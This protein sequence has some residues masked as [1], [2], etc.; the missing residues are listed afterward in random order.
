MLRR[1]RLGVLGF[2]LV[3][4]LFAVAVFDA[5]YVHVQSSQTYI[6]YAVALPALALVVARARRTAVPRSMSV[7]IVVWVEVAVAHAAIAW[8]AQHPTNLVGSDLAAVLMPVVVLFAALANPAIVG[9]QATKIVLAGLAVAAVVAA[10]VPQVAGRHEKPSTLIAAAS[11]LW[12]ADRPSW[13]RAAA[14]GAVAYLGWSSGFRTSLLIWVA[15]GFVALGGRH[16]R[17]RHAMVVLAVGLGVLA[18]TGAVALDDSDRRLTV[19]D[20]SSIQRVDEVKDAWA[21]ISEWPAWQY[22]VGAGFGGQFEAVEAAGSRGVDPSTGRLHQM[23]HGPGMVLYRLGILGVLA[24]GALTVAVVRALRDRTA[25][26]VQRLLAVAMFGFL[27]EF[28]V[29]NVSLYPHFWWVLA[30][31]LFYRYRTTVAVDREVALVG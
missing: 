26:P 8:Y 28:L 12:F 31:F 13:R 5:L 7:V 9:E 23:H 22:P 14:V 19:N 18:A 6:G 17:V 29:L 11:W 15:V 4:V 3:G 24:L 10:A 20:P 27:C 25:P 1:H 2:L 16:R 30:G 21:A